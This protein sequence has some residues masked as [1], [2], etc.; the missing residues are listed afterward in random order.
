MCKK[1]DRSVFV[2]T[3]VLPVLLGTSHFCLGQQSLADS[4]CDGINVEQAGFV[5]RSSHIDDPFDFL[6]WVRARER[7]AERRIAVLINGRPFRYTT[8]RDAALRIIEEENFLPDTREMRVKI[9]VE[10]VHI[11]N[12]SNGFLDLFYRVYSTQIM[13]VLSGA[14]ELRV[15]ERQKPEEAAGLVNVDVPEVRPI[16]LTP[17]AGYDATDKLFGGFR[18]KLVPKSVSS[19]PISSASFD[20]QASSQMHTI[21]A[22]ITGSREGS[23]WLAHLEWRIDFSNFSV[24][25]GNGKLKGGN[26]STQFSGTTRSF[27]G[28][29]LIVRFGGLLEGGHR[30]SDLANARFTAD[31]L[32]DSPL[33]ALKLFVGAASR[34]RHNSLSASYGLQLGVAGRTVRVDWSKQIVD[35]KHE[36]WYSV[37]DHRT[38]DLESRFSAGHIEI[39]GKIPLAERFF[40]GANEESFASTDS[41]Q[42]RGNPV[43][44]A[45]PGRRLFRTPSGD[46]GDDFLNYNFTAAYAVWRRPLVSSKL[47]HDNDFHDLLEAQ[48]TNAESFEQ[49]HF[50]TKDKHYLKLAEFIQKPDD[51]PLVQTALG[52]LST[53]VSAAKASHPGQYV[54]EFEACFDSIDDANSRAKSGAK[55]KGEQQY[56]FLVALLSADDDLLSEVNRACI[57]TLNGSAVLNGDPAIAAAGRRID[58]IRVAMENEYSQIDQGAAENMAKEDMV[59]V[60]RTLGTLLNDLNIYSISPVFVFDIARLSSKQ[61]GLGGTRFGPGAGLRLELASAAQ[62]TAGYAWNT[63]PGPG[64]GRGSI[65]F[66][67]AI[68]D[69]FR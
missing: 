45:I 65:F 2:L 33:G 26:L 47:S 19:S 30:Q 20:G 61:G 15:E 38:L 39:P 42:I 51:G 52:G 40:G 18:L 22:A 14:P 12:C 59:F 41:W 24:P 34:F 37:G 55:A 23:G 13:P 48:L 64:E 46:G 62:F 5:V 56:G 66:S 29:N 3:L 21:N 50:L 8:A 1:I 58:Q 60:R 44:R 16:Y 10:F 4:S 11:Q 28:G 31:T 27:G 54:T 32:A 36:F 63:R 53:G 43:I 17:T 57:E 6:P 67:I 25:T 69:L 7:R 49:L 9:R 68:R 35:I